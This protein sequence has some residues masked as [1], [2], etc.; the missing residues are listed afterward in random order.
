MPNS[1]QE[2]KE[3]WTGILSPWPLTLT[4]PLLAGPLGRTPASPDLEKHYCTRGMRKPRC[5]PEPW[6]CHHQLSSGDEETEVPWGDVAF[7]RAGS[8]GSELDPDSELRATH[9]RAGLEAVSSAQVDIPLVSTRRRPQTFS[10]ASAPSSACAVSPALSQL[11][12]GASSWGKVRR[13]T[14]PPSPSQPTRYGGASF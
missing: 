7:A 6:Y 2:W 13:H 8:D 14:G 9:Y 12:L 5:G 1:T 3:H 11:G 10:W 4:R